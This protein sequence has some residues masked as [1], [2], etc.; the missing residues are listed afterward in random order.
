MEYCPGC[1]SMLVDGMT[2]KETCKPKKR[3][4]PQPEAQI[5]DVYIPE[6]GSVF[7]YYDLSQCFVAGTMI[8]TPIG[9]KPIDKLAV[10]DLVFTYRDRRPAIGHVT[11]HIKLLKRPTIKVTLDTGV[12]IRCT[13][14]HKWLVCPERQDDD[15]VPRRADALRPN[16]RLLPF[17]KLYNPNDGRETL[18]AHKAIE[19]SKTHVEVARAVYGERPEGHDVHH[20]DGDCRNNAPD[21]LEYK[22]AF[23]HK[24]DHGR[25]VAAKCWGTPSIRKKMVA[26]LRRHAAQRDISGEN[27][28]RFGDR[29]QRGFAKC[30]QCGKDFEYFKTRSIGKFCSKRCYGDSKIRPRPPCAICGKIVRRPSMLFCGIKCKKAGLAKGLNHRVVSVERD[31]PADVWSIA[32]S[33][34]HNYALAAGVFVNNCEMRYA[35]N[36]SGDEAFIAACGKDV[37]AGNAKVIFAGIPG[38][39]EALEKDP[40]GAGKG[41]RDVAKNVGFAISYLAEAPKLFMHL[42]EHGFNVD[43]AQCEEIISRIHQAYWRYYQF[44]EENVRLCKRQGFLRTPILGRKRWYGYWPKPTEIAAG[45]IQS[46]VADT[47]NERLLLIESR[48]PPNCHQLIYAYDAAIYEVPSARVKEVEDLLEEVWAEPVKLPDGRTFMQPIDRKVGDRWSYFG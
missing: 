13:P 29:R 4:D 8:D 34:D 11:Q 26:G 25:E 33:P 38:A 42:I 35:A 24:S 20:K 43:L 12:E 3:K 28:P 45:P 9:A 46:S 39:V 17:R 5:R 15:P 7:V 22:L 6:E 27:N 44:V 23:D 21:N 16:D 47:M 31:A 14:D 1:G 36:I 32:V 18:Y 2:H 30:E 41:F 37:H 48:L 10:G 19:W 40:K